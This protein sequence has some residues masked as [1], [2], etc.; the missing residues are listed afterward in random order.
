[1]NIQKKRKNS[2]IINTNKTQQPNEL[3]SKPT[4]GKKN[5]ETKNKHQK[6]FFLIIPASIFCVSLIINIFL[7]AQFRQHDLFSHIN[8][9]TDSFGF[10]ETAKVIAS[11][12][13]IGEGKFNQEPGYY[14][15]LAIIIKMAGSNVYAIRIIQSAIGSLTV[16]S[17]YYITYFLFC[18]STA[19]LISSSLLILCGV[20]Y[21]YNLIILRTFLTSFLI[22]S[23][24]TSFIL[25]LKSDSKK[26]IFFT[27]CLTGLSFLTQPNV[28][29]FF[30]AAVAV[31]FFSPKKNILLFI[32]GFSLIFGILG[33]RNKIAG[34]E[35]LSFSN[36]GAA[37][38]A[39]GNII[40]SNGVGWVEHPKSYWYA[41]KYQTL[42][43]V[44]VNVIKDSLINDPQKYFK[45][46]LNKTAAA[47][48][49]YEVPNNYNFYYFKKYYI[50]DLKYFPVNFGI[51]F[52]L[53]SI[54]ISQIKF[55]K[56]FNFHDKIQ[57]LYITTLIFYFLTIISFY[58]I[59]RFRFPVLILM[60]PYAGYGL[61]SIFYNFRN[62]IYKKFFTQIIIG[63]AAVIITFFY[64]V[65]GIN[66]NSDMALA[67]ANDGS[68]Y[69]E[70]NLLDK[71]IERYD[72]A[73]KYYPAEA[74]Y[75]T[76]IK[77][78]IRNNN[79][80]ASLKYCYDGLQL[81]NNSADLIYLTAYNHIFLKNHNESVKFLLKI[82]DSANYINF[83]IYNLALEYYY[84]NDY[85][86]SLIYWEKYYQLNPDDDKARLNIINLKLW[87]TKQKNIK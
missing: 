42:T 17:V 78:C 53:F 43:G 23:C 37:E 14:Y 19:A 20:H 57:I 48:N 87:Q 85:N 1:M 66:K 34:T 65:E 67:Y 54:G 25:Y 84:L 28:I 59:S 68:A 21:Y 3:L 36:K 41:K 40:E 69:S 38:F 15:F 80:N 83:K 63:S 39:S 55:S 24:I 18:N 75:A 16:V 22:L 30:I 71:S 45:L 79:Y 11:S 58:I 61:L 35:L 46:I 64:P 29:S 51:I 56:T 77:L 72:T 7:L 50:S 2:K 32:L 47:L 27:G 70:L 12:N 9:V 82:P 6:L 33:I 74:G 52:I 60:T 5:S 13:F 81:Y 49:N 4:D 26:F 86:T 10:I 62:K 73:L 31:L 8:K 44:I 76:I